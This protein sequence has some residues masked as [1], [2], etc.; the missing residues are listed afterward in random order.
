M[1]VCNQVFQSNVCQLET[2]CFTL[3]CDPPIELDFSQYRSESNF[4]SRKVWGRVYY[5]VMCIQIRSKNRITNMHFDHEIINCSRHFWTNNWS[6]T[7]T[8]PYRILMAISRNSWWKKSHADIL[9]PSHCIQ[10]SRFYLFTNE[11]CI[12]DWTQIWTSTESN[13]MPTFTM[14]ISHDVSW[15]SNISNHDYTV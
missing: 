5:H 11:K 15:R 6:P 10:R 4:W 8:L 1:Q 2:K 14:W 3:M 12:S 13:D 7:Y 9:P